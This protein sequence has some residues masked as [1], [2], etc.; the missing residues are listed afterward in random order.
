MD[1]TLQRLIREA[2]RS[3]QVDSVILSLLPHVHLET[4]SQVEQWS[5]KLHQHLKTISQQRIN[6]QQTCKH[7]FTSSPQHLPPMTYEDGPD[8]DWYIECRLC[9]IVEFVPPPNARGQCDVARG[10]CACGAF[11]GRLTDK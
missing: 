5:E 2:K 8:G 3:G 1:E 9:Q 11:H 10:P 6:I 4:V 7:E